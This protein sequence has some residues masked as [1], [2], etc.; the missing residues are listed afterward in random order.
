MT[1]YEPAGS[2]AASCANG[3]A[4]DRGQTRAISAGQ[5]SSLCATSDTPAVKH[6]LGAF[7]RLSAVSLVN[8]TGGLVLGG[9]GF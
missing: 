2:Q 8:K 3:V 5:A 6:G 7:P 9:N 1:T 4:R